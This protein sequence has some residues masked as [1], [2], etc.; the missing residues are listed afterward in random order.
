MAGSF[1]SCAVI[2][3]KAW[4]MFIGSKSGV[5][6]D[7]RFNQSV[8]RRCDRSAMVAMERPSTAGSAMWKAGLPDG[9]LPAGGWAAGGWAAG[10][11]AASGWA[12]DGVAPPL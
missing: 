12:E 7:W 8:T 3:M 5:S 6:C 11:W 10:G 9:G 4:P 1:I 2:S